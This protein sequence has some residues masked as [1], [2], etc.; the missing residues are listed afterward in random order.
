MRKISAEKTIERVKDWTEV[1]P[2]MRKQYFEPESQLNMRRA[3]QSMFTSSQTI[4]NLTDKVFE[5]EWFAS[6]VKEFKGINNQLPKDYKSK[7]RII[8]DKIDV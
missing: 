4:M 3:T 1:G 5:V 7:I 2:A 8:I 6:K